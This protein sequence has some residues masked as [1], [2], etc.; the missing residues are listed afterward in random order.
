MKK[1]LF[2]LFGLVVLAGCSSYDYY[3]GDVRYVQDGEDCIFTATEAG[4]RY[5]SDIRE[6]N[7]DKEIVYRNTMCR[8]LYLNDV[9]GQMSRTE[10]Q[11]LTTVAPKTVKSDCGCCKKKTAKK[12]VF[13]K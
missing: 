9:A 7:A 10:R 4:Y 12:Y 13:V 11:V 2:V 6:L 1:T 8:D 3:K 5:S